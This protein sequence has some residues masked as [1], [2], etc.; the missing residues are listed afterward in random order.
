MLPMT[1][2]QFIQLRKR[3]TVFYFLN[4]QTKISKIEYHHCIKITYTHSLSSCIIYGEG[5]SFILTPYLHSIIYCNYTSSTPGFFTLVC[6]NYSFLCF[7]NCIEFFIHS[8]HRLFYSSITVSIFIGLNSNLTPSSLSRLL[9]NISLFKVV[10]MLVLK[11]SQFINL[12]F[13]VSHDYHVT[14]RRTNCSVI[15]CFF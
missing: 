15:R 4:Y 3:P 9:L 7:W 10:L 1:E 11:H 2:K 13:N 6:S 12:S 5:F 14:T 8:Y